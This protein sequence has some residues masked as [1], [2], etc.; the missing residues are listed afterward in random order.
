[1]KPSFAESE[2]YVI[3]L[4]VIIIFIKKDIFFF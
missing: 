1:M 2:I 3:Y 4:Q